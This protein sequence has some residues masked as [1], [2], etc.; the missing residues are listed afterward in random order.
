MLQQRYST[1][2]NLS[3]KAER[4]FT[5]L[6]EAEEISITLERILVLRRGRERWLHFAPQRSFWGNWQTAHS[7]YITLSYPQRDEE[8]A[9]QLLDDLDQDV[10]DMCNALPED[11]C[12]PDFLLHIRLDNDPRSLVDMA[13]PSNILTP[14]A[15]NIVRLPTPSLVGIPV[16]EDGY[17]ALRQ[18]YAA[19]VL[20][21][22]ITA[23]VHYTCC[24]NGLLYQA[25]ID[26]HLSQF[27]LRP[28]PLGIH[29]Y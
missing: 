3:Q 19:H 13:D 28:W 23:N 7:Q 26:K 29:E 25:L 16:D 5:S 1:A 21:A 10:A 4:N 22:A 6:A 27:G 24:E 9:E 15:G 8:L 17:Q 2:A 11:N 12:T 20:T 18:G 14:A